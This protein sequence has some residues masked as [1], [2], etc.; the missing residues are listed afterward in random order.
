MRTL[1]ALVACASGP[2]QSSA[3]AAT[4]H[5]A[6]SA[7]VTPEG[8]LVVDAALHVL[9]E[10]CP[11]PTSCGAPLRPDG[12]V[13]GFAAGSGAP[14][15]AAC[16]HVHL[17][18]LAATR[19]EME[20]AL[21]ALGADATTADDEGGDSDASSMRLARKI[22][23]G[24]V[25]LEEASVGCLLMGHVDGERI[26]CQPETCGAEEQQPCTTEHA[27]HLLVTEHRL[28]DFVDRASGGEGSAGLD[29]G[30]GKRLM[31][32]LVETRAEMAR[33]GCR[34]LMD[35]AGDRTAIAPG[36]RPPVDSEA[37]TPWDEAKPAMRRQLPRELREDDELFVSFASA[38]HHLFQTPQTVHL[39]DAFYDI[40]TQID[41][42]RLVLE[43]AGTGDIP[44]LSTRERSSRNDTVSK[45]SAEETQV[46]HML[47]HLL[48]IR[49]DSGEVG[50]VDFYP[51]Y[52]GQWQGSKRGLEEGAEDE[53]DN[54]W[55]TFDRLL[56]VNEGRDYGEEDAAK[57]REVDDE[58]AKV[59]KEA[60]LIRQLRNLDDS[61]G[62]RRARDGQLGVGGSGMQSSPSSSGQGSCPNIPKGVPCDKSSL[63]A[64]LM[65]DLTAQR[66][67]AEA[68]ASETERTGRARLVRDMEERLMVLM[69]EQK[70]CD[71][72]KMSAAS[73]ARLAGDGVE[74]GL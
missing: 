71:M 5:R 17:A 29:P 50:P 53:D 18:G 40:R 11:P 37:E 59:E 14:A 10:L 48:Q 24:H 54:F 1:L 68:A 41:M 66:E 35:G 61:S 62:R 57:Q 16:S 55:E 23:L 30:E 27:E 7:S 34:I 63:L 21:D 22:Q 20:K 44:E 58:R 25:S 56:P 45:L 13:Y 72:A 42:Q 65:R 38:N 39:I 73:P 3:A 36:E 43:T 60:N 26:A 31:L 19:Q 6:V 28:R 8:G 15:K 12:G 64:G 51:N 33:V 9:D 4:G 49:V 52:R 67:R 70:C 74:L 32:K 69:H 2:S 46:R 47:M